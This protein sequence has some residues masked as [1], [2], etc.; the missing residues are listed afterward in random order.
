MSPFANSNNYGGMYVMCVLVEK[1]VHWRAVS[2]RDCV[3]TRR[4]RSRHGHHHLFDTD[5][6]EQ[7]YEHRFGLLVFVFNVFNPKRFHE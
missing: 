1:K 2:F 5:L 3:R 7:G 4:W 6:N